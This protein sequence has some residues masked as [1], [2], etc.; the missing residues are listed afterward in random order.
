MTWPAKAARESPLVKF[1]TRTIRSS[2]A[3]ANLCPAGE[4][5]TALAPP[6]CAGIVRITAA[7]STSQSLNVPSTWEVASREPS[8][9]NA[10]SVAA[11][12]LPSVVCRVQ[13]AVFQK[14]SDPPGPPAAS[15]A[16]SGANAMAM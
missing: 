16:P 13:L 7:L 15:V 11:G 8:G 3:D 1:Q 9:E 4:K 10:A 2:P 14:L 5:D 12:L 6:G